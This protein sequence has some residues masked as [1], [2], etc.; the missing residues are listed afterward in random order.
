VVV[1]QSL[2]LRQQVKQPKSAIKNKGSKKQSVKRP[3]PNKK[4]TKGYIQR[5]VFL[6]DVAGL[7]F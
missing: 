3:K 6:L 4:H 2:T 7:F 1:H 5:Q